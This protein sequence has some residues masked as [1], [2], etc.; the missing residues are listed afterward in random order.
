MPRVSP[1]RDDLPHNHD[2]DYFGGLC[3]YLGREADELEGFV[4]APATE[5]VG[6]GGVGVLVE[7]RA[8]PG[9]LCRGDV[10]KGDHQGQ[11]TIHKHQK[12][13]VG[14][15]FTIIGLCHHSFLLAVRNTIRVL[16]C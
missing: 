13:G 11:N 10:G 2:R 8:V 7:R 15:L 12:L 4:L 14:K 9:L 1:I 5:S 3:Q 16:G 6:D